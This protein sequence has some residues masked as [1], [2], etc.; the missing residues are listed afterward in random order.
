MILSLTRPQTTRKRNRNTLLLLPVSL[1]VSSLIYRGLSALGGHT[2]PHPKSYPLL[3][4]HNKRPRMGEGGEGGEDGKENR[5]IR[6]GFLCRENARTL[7]MI[8]RKQKQT[9][10]N[11]RGSYGILAFSGDTDSSALHVHFY[12]VT[13]T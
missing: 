7:L 13:S 1:S 4:R 8:L 11:P 6:L 3:G 2:N 10:R 12:V 9:T 5:P